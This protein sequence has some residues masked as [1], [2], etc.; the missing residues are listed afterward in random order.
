MLASDALNTQKSTV[1]GGLLAGRQYIKH[2]QAGT[3]ASSAS[4]Q[5]SFKWVAPNPVSGTARFY[6]A[7]NAANNN[8]TSGGDFIYVAALSVPPAS[9][10]VK[11][12]DCNHNGTVNVI[13]VTYLVNYLF[14]GGPSPSCKEEADVNDSGG[15]NVVD[16]SQ[17]VSYLFKGGSVGLCP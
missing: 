13:D 8:G 5:W 2:T 12:G 1:P 4:G 15:V 6:V 9:C 17:I 14:K 10:C 11:E 3:Y 16:L 7:G